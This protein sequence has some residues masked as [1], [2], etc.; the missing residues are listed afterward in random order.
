M[1]SVLPLGV[2]GL[3]PTELNPTSGYLVTFG[4]RNIL[5]DIGSGVFNKLRRETPI[6]DLEAIIITHY[7]F[8]HA[9]DI[10]VLSYYLQTKNAK[11]KVYAPCDQSPY[12]KLIENSPYLDYIPIEE[13]NTLK[14]GDAEIN[15]YKTRHP[16]LTFAVEINYE[17]KKFSYSS[18]GNLTKAF[19]KLFS[20]CDL[21]IIDCGL[22]KKDWTE[23]KP[24]LSAY[25]VGFL[26]KTYGIKKVLVSHFNPTIDKDE[27]IREA[28]S[29]YDGCAPAEYK[30]Y[31]I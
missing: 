26:G 31:I 9:S 10:G 13:N 15:F 16:V 20:S 27:I 2:N 12:Q 3:Y 7:H 28:V 21:A 29:E 17:G 25:H 6:E 5:I 30:R 24:L 1:F 8:D 23:E 19:E 4:K 18:D 14:I 11:L 22:L